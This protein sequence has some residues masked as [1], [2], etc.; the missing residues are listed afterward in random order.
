MNDPD[1]ITPDHFRAMPKVEL[2]CHLDGSM[3]P[4][5]MLEL[6]REQNVTLPRSTPD[7]LRA[8][9]RADNVTNLEDYLARFDATISV[10]QTADALERAA[11][12][13]VQDVHADGVRYIEVRNAPRLNTRRGLTDDEVMDA[14]MRGLARAEAQFGTVARFICCTLRHWS[15]RVSIEMAELAVR[16]MDRGVVGFDMAGGEAGNPAGEHAA[17][18]LYAREH[19]LDVTCH[20]GEGDGPESIEQALFLCGAYR[21]GHGV[22]AGENPALLR[23]LRDRQIPLE[24]CPTSNV[25]THAV[26][27]FAQHPVK[28]YLDY[29]VAVTLNTDNR[30]I[31]GITLSSEFAR[32]VNELGFTSG[33][34]ARCVMNGCRAAFLPL[35]EREQLAKSIADE[36]VR[37]WSYVA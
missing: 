22:R 33:N 7:A 16:Y 1:E 15:P 14:T 37:D 23:F 24:L 36:L 10:L 35:P 19:F 28:R 17:A 3:R 20:A 8:Y 18:F 9:M 29:G 6:A 26:A 4:E 31:S 30:L 5:T 27:S 21:I 34:L 11:Y 25:Q 13:L 12:E 32:L 2:H